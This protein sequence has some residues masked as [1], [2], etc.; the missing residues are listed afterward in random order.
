MILPF[1]TQLL[2]F[3]GISTR[4]SGRAVTFLTRK[5]SHTM[6]ASATSDHALSYA[7]YESAFFSF[8][9][10]AQKPGNIEMILFE[11]PAS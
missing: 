10:F 7:R 11:A 6:P 5:R 8:D 9:D 2:R 3:A 1:Q 4:A